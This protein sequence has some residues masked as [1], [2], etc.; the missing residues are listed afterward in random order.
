MTY[1]PEFKSEITPEFLYRELERISQELEL[2]RTGHY[3]IT[4]V[5][6]SKP[7]SG[8]I[9]YADGTEWNPGAG[10]GLYRYNIG[11]YWVKLSNENSFVSVTEYG[12]VGDG[13]TDDTVAIQAT[14]DAAAASKSSVFFPAGTY[15]ISSVLTC[16]NTASLKYDG[17]VIFGEGCGLNNVG[18]E[19]VFS[20]TSGQRWVFSS[21]SASSAFLDR[22]VIR[23]IGL[24]ISG[25]SPSGALIRLRRVFEIKFENVYLRGNN[26]T[27]YLID[28]NEWVDLRFDNCYFRDAAYGIATVSVSGYTSFANVI[29]FNACTFDDL[30][31]ATDFSLAGRSIKFDTCTWEPA[32]SGA[33]SS[34]LTGNYN[35]YF[36]NCWFGDA[37]TS[38]TWI[39]ATGEQLSLYD[40][41]VLTGSVGVDISTSFGGEIVRGR[42]QANTVAID[43]GATRKVTVRGARILLASDNS[44]GIDVTAGVSHC[45]VDNH[46]VESG[47]RTGTTAYRLGAGTSGYFRDNDPGTV[48]TTIDN[49]ATAGAWT[50]VDQYT[51]DVAAIDANQTRD[52][53]SINAG[54]VGTFDVT[55]T[56]AEVGDAAIVT[57]PSGLDA[58]LVFCAFVTAS[59]TVT[60]RMIN[61]TASPIDVASGTWRVKVIKQTS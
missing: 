50:V 17:L 31:T 14:L 56:G 39:T 15:L 1:R 35:T 11:G 59:N 30:T 13:V 5:E 4:Y 12:A 53:A 48:D 20:V 6:P 21:Q 9:R 41:E 25:S 55:A 34:N 43:I 46:V 7:R 58:G 22:V 26:G 60:V 49:N 27:E 10:E 16:V 2:I 47:T 51:R 3:D 38:G 45:L 36:Y 54:E 23:D 8:D 37:N 32:E 28:G 40:C 52:P 19:I 42:Y 29:Q 33:A 18:T 44:V 24:R 61:G 57:P